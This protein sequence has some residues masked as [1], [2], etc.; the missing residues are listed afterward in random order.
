MGGTGRGMNVKYEE[1]ELKK[2]DV[3]S[4][5]VPSILFC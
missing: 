5:R 1:R 4:G 2:R 3:N